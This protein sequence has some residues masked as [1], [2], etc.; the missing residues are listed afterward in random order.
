M[1]KD[2][3]K[4][5]MRIWRNANPDKIKSQT[6]SYRAKHLEALTLKSKTYYEKNKE[7][8]KLQ[9]KVS[10][11]KYY[12]ENREK[13]IEATK[14]YRKNNKTVRYK[15]EKERKEMDPL[16]RLK[17]NLR[18]SILKAFKNNHYAKKSKTQIILGCS[19]DEFKIHLE[20]KFESW[21]NWNNHGKYNGLQN[22]T[23]QLDHKIP[24]SSAKTEEDV[25]KLS[26][27]SNYQPLCSFINQNIKRNNL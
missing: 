12:E 9:A 20:S 23:W 19:F 24:I 2:E 18:L 22:S 7:T 1:T 13:L 3:R 26:H 14:L 8:L 16:Y 11:K 4:E 17:D 5:Y 25:I 27:Y 15:R 6:K 21:M 10:N